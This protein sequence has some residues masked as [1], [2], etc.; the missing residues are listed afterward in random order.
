MGYSSRQ[1]VVEPKRGWR[2]LVE[3]L[4]RRLAR[5]R[6]RW[7]LIEVPFELW[8]LRVYK[9]LRRVPAPAVIN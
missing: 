5:R 4:L 7:L 8:A 1:M 6:L 9:A 3:R 2:G